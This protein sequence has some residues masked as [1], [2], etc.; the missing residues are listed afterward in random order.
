MES[1]PKPDGPE[2]FDAALPFKAVVICCTS[3]AADLRTELDHQAGQMGGTHKYDL[4]PDVT[5]LIVGEYNTP[6]YRH[7]ARERPDVK[8]MAAGWIQAVRD[9][10]VNDKEIDFHKL[11]AEWTLKPFETSGGLAQED[12][13]RLLCCLTGFLDSEQRQSIEDTVRANGGNYTGDLS[14]A[15]SHLIVYQP[16]G[17]KYKAAKNWG[18]PTVCIEWLQDS[19]ERGMILDEKCYDPALPKGER[20]KGAWM[21][22]EAKRILSGKRPREGPPAAPDDGRRKL[23]KTASMKLDKQSA[24]L[25]DDILFKQPSANPQATQQRAGLEQRAVTMPV[26]APA[27]SSLASFTVN[28]PLSLPQAGAGQS[29]PDGRIFSGCRFFVHG[30]S[31]QQSQVVY[32]HLESHGAQISSSLADAASPVHP[33]EQRFLLVPQSSQPNTHPLL[34]DGVHIV[35]EF[36]IERCIYY[37]RLFDPNEHVFGRPFPQF[38]IEGFQKLTIS[39]AGFK[40]VQTHQVSKTVTQ[41]GAEYRA[42]LN[43]QSSLLICPSIDEVS[44][45]KLDFCLLTKIPVVNMEWL[46]Q[47]ITTG[48]LVPWDKFL[49]PE[50][51]QRLS[52]DVDPALEKE[53]QKLKRSRSEPAAKQK[54]DFRA[55][56]SKATVDRTAFENNTP[57]AQAREGSASEGKD[58][59]ESYYET[60]RSNLADSVDGEQVAAPLTEVSENVL[61][62]SPSAKLD[63]LDQPPRMPLQRFPTGGTIADSEGGDESDAASIR[64]DKAPS[65]PDV[66]AARNRKAEDAEM[67]QKRLADEAEAARKR[68]V[69]EEKT[70][71]RLALAK[72]LMS[73][74]DATAEAA[75]SEGNESFNQASAV[76]P[77]RRKREILGRAVS[78]VSATSSASAESSMTATAT[79]VPQQP[80]ARRV[81][82]NKS[83]PGALGLLEGMLDGRDMSAETEGEKP[84]A[85]TQL[86]YDNP[87]ARKHRA[88]VVDRMMGNKK[89][90]PRKS[91]EKPTLEG[92]KGDDPTSTR[93]SRRR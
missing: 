33:E 87:E 43:R 38:P 65:V 36:Y 16:E 51:K 19:V 50:L 81:D 12:R 84:P 90:A 52:I 53:R 78:N 88:A 18:I 26:T 70:A 24:N 76:G 60:A 61:N 63:Q 83:A 7:V 31:R 75:A 46:Y 72:N 22:K 66:E 37:K 56:P 80:T 85:A 93:R 42:S 39:T 17:K 45:Q 79:K 58:P 32:E 68:K 6:K 3:V 67:T 27:G 57:L 64:T 15:V 41:L 91:L 25:W 1:F 73:L 14:K 82:S 49:F 35:T 29:Q 69:E 21:P 47:C 89:A 2:A 13:G 44:K 54:A 23:R 62:K 86:D 28:H 34:P 71:E 30:F 10:W 4:T 92:L 55:P 9:L 48:F 59:N 77:K 5:H 20:G 40:D 11:E 74:V 8:P